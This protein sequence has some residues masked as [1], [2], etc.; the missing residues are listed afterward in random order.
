MTPT[1]ALLQLRTN[2][3]AFLWDHP[4]SVAGGSIGGVRTAAFGAGNRKWRFNVDSAGLME[5]EVSTQVWNFPMIQKNQA[6]VWG[7]VPSTHVNGTN[8]LIVVTGML[9]GCT[10]AISKVSDTELHLSH[11]QPGGVRPSGLETEN[12]MRQSAVLNG[13]APTHFY[14][15]SKYLNGC[16]CAHVIGV[17]VGGAW[18]LWGQGL[19]GLYGEKVAFIHRIL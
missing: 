4:V 19:T 11:V 12:Q 10:V 1:Q 17:A 18:Q 16:N 6:V 8:P 13:Q 2:P 15:P 7:T 14:G 5:E 9:T 3:R